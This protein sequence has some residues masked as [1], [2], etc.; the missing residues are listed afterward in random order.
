LHVFKPDQSI[1]TIDISDRGLL[2]IGLGRHVQILKNAFSQPNDVTYLKHSIRTPNRSLCAGAGVV[3]SSKA[4]LSSVSVH[5][6]RFRPY[7][8]SLCI[9]HSHG[10]T[11][12][13]VPGSGEPNFDT[14]ENNPYITRNQRREQEVQTLLNKL[15]ADLI[16]LGQ[17]VANYSLFNSKLIIC[18][19]IL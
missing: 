13:I 14:Y 3:A 4:L 15:P 5:C 17:F 16:G 18:F 1:S 11:S 2:A 12:I 19:H 9:G 10:I 7:E 8:D 6:V